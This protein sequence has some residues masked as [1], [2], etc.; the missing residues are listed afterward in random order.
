MH[1]I[2][3]T[4]LVSTVTIGLVLMIYIAALSTLRGPPR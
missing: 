1:D 2:A 4:F 3:L